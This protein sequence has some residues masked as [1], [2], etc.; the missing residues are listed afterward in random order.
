MDNVPLDASRRYLLR[1]G[2]TEAV[3]PSSMKRL[4]VALPTI[5]EGMKQSWSF[6]WRS[7]MAGEL[8]FVEGRAHVA[9]RDV[10]RAQAIFKLMSRR[11]RTP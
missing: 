10:V 1:E 8:V 6:A 11:P 7:L 4:L 3:V 9:G 5:W 2:A